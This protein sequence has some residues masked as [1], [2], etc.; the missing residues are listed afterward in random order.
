MPRLSLIAI[1][2]GCA[3]MGGCR[4]S[5]QRLC[6]EMADY[7]VETCNLS[8]GSED[9]KTCRSDHNGRATDRGDLEACE[10]ASAALTEGEWT[11]DDVKEYFKADGPVSAK[12]EAEEP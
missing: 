9:L 2:L 6:G 12:V 7:A 1:L 5:C 4:N 3:S 11:C 8:F 10:L